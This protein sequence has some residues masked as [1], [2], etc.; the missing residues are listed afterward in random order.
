TVTMLNLVSMAVILMVGE[1]ATW[2]SGLAAQGTPS[3]SCPASDRRDASVVRKLLASES[4]AGTERGEFGP[5]RGASVRPLRTDSDQAVCARLNELF[6]AATDGS[7]SRSYYALDKYY[8][9]VIQRE[10]STRPRSEFTPVVIL[11]HDLNPVEIL[12]M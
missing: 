2:P 7:V 6:P 10:R 12:A 9:V 8:L 11:D 3:A 4:R 5:S 1:A